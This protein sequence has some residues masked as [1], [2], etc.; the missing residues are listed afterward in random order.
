[1]LANGQEGKWQFFLAAAD[2][3]PSAQVH[4]A[5]S[6]C[7]KSPPAARALKCSLQA[8]QTHIWNRI[9]VLKIT[10]ELAAKANRRMI[11]VPPSARPERRPNMSAGSQHVWQQDQVVLVHGLAANRMIMGTLAKSL[12]KAF[13]KV[14]NWGYRS[15]WSPIERHGRQLADVLRELDDQ[16]GTGRIH[17]VTHSMGGIIAR[18]ALAE[19][20]PRRFGRLVMIAPPNR[21]SHVAAWL[22]PYLGSVCPPLVQLSCERESFVCSLPPPKVN[23]LG[24]IAADKDYLVYEDSVRLGCESDYIMLPGLHSSLLWSP[25]TAEQVQH[26]LAN[27]HFRRAD[28]RNDGE[29]PCEVTP[30]SRCG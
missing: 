3:F 27:G 16:A 14:V 28:C 25:Q 10:D 26:F 15:L 30:L 9:C 4:G 17:L 19:F 1:M 5:A 24:I 22:A 7:P 6:S 13:G 20:L 21:G 2:A 8:A 23:E 11:E 12:G 18:V 29:G